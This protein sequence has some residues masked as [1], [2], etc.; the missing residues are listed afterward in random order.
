VK[1]PIQL[2]GDP[3]YEAIQAIYGV[4]RVFAAVFVAEIGDVH[5]FASAQALCS[6]AGLVSP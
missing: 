6:W 4:G 2:R 1:V 3:G 5:R